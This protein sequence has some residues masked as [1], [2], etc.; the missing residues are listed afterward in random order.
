[1]VEKMMSKVFVVAV[2]AAITSLGAT[3]AKADEQRQAKD[4][5]PA[6]LKGFQGMM[7]GALLKKGDAQLVIKLKKITKVWKGNKAENPKKAVGVELTL[8]LK[9]VS[10]HHR[11]RIM[12][13]FAS[14]KEGDKIELEAFDLGEQTLCIK[15]WLRK[16]EPK[17]NDKD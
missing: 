1:M 17:G 13:N 5:I 8:N 12:A 9:K 10:D 3:L 16:V 4:G 14:L 15:E 6:E 11:E 2:L 7:R